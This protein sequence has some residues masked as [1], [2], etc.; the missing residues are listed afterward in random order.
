MHTWGEAR[1]QSTHQE[2]QAW[3]VVKFGRRG[4]M[5]ED[6]ERA[7]TDNHLSEGPQPPVPVRGLLGTGPHSRR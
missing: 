3:R 6:D 4:E 5:R 1:G 2:I 7:V